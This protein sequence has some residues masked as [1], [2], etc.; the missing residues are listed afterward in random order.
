MVKLANQVKHKSA[1]SHYV[2]HGHINNNYNIVKTDTKP[3]INPEKQADKSFVVTRST[4][5]V[6]KKGNKC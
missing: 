1:C 4:S 5:I 6:S 3:N 2:N